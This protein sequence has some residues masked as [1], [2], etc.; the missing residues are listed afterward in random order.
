FVKIGSSV[1]FD[2]NTFTSPSYPNLQ[3]QAYN[4]GAR[5]SSNSW[6]SSS[7]AYTADS[8]SY[9][10]LVRDAQPTGST[11]PTAGN[12]EMV[13][14]FAAGNSGSSA[15]TV[16]APATGKNVLVV[17]AAEN[18]RSMSTTNGGNNAAGNDG[19]GTPDTDADSA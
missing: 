16:H 7:N 19:C 14:V 13:I 4:D 10:A 1:I 5:I 17:G 8:Q 11:F 2:P 6:G 15:N 9:D 12:Q 3:S 18:V